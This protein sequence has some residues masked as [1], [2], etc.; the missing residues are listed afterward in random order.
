MPLF[1]TL[2]LLLLALVLPTAG[3]LALRLLAPRMT[4]SQSYLVAAV[5]FAL[6][7]TSVLVLARASTNSVQIGNLSLLA[8][9]VGE[10][11]ID[12][13]IDLPMTVLPE[14]DDPFAQPTDAPAATV[15]AATDAP[16]PT[17]TTAA[18][19]ATTAPIATAAPTE[20][21]APTTAPEPTAAP[22][23]TTAQAPQRRT[24]VVQSGDTLRSI[25]EQFN[26]SVQALLDANNLTPEQAD[27]LRVGSEL[28]IP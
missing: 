10:E 11:M 28:V 18:E 2:L 14:Q 15:P 7:F 25:A 4:A 16:A 13:P 21:T 27:A 26:V 23:P 3:A 20:T 17:A 24:Y 1:L 6:A 8:P 9:N 5:V 22:V 12:L 19:T